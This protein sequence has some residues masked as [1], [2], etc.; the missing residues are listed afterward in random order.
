MVSPEVTPSKMRFLGKKNPRNLAG[1]RGLKS[2]A[3]K[4]EGSNDSPE[5]IL[6]YHFIYDFGNYFE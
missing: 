5:T 1:F 3:F 2:R 6:I 4:K